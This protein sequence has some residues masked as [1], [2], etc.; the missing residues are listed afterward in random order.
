MHSASRDHTQHVRQRGLTSAPG[1]NEMGQAHSSLDCGLVGILW[2]GNK[3]EKNRRTRSG[4]VAQCVESVPGVL[5]VMASIPSITKG[6]GQEE[7]VPVSVSEGNRKDERI[8]VNA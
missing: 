8:S 3:Q 2:H 7:T 4:H 1:Q 6:G 5:G